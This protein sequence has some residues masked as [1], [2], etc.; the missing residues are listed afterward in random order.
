MQIS[1]EREPASVILIQVQGDGREEGLDSGVR[2]P[3]YWMSRRKVRIGIGVG[4]RWIPLCIL[5]EPFMTSLR[6]KGWGKW[7]LKPRTGTNWFCLS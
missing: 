4:T 1:G 3:E 5:A 6:A 7:I 2:K